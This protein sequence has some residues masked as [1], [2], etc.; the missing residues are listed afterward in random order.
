MTVRTFDLGGE[1]IA[2]SLRDH[3][4]KFANPALGLRAIRLSL[5]HRRLLDPQFGAMLRAA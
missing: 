5:Q 2:R 4:T 1:K 3:I